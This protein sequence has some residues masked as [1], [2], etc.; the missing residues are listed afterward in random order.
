[1]KRLLILIILIFGFEHLKSQ[2]IEIGQDANEVK[3]FIEWSTRQRTGFDSY[4]NSMGNNVTWD[5][6]YYNGQITEVIQCYEN[7]VIINL[8]PSV[9]FSRHYN[10]EFG[11]LANVYTQYE[12][13]SVE[14]LIEKYNKI[15]EGR[16]INNL[17]FENDYRHYTKIFLAKNGYATTDFRIIDDSQL[18]SSMRKT[19]KN[20]MENEREKLNQ[21]RLADE[22]EKE[23]IHEIIFKT[24]D[25]EK[26]SKDSYESLISGIKEEIINYFE[27]LKNPRYVEVIKDPLFTDL[28]NFDVKKYRFKNTY[29]AYFKYE[30]KSGIDKSN[31]T[32]IDNESDD[33]YR[34]NEITLISGNDTTC[35][36]FNYIAIFIPELHINGYEVLTEVH[37]RNINVDYA[38][39]I[40]FI[41]AKNGEIDFLANKP[42]NDLIDR[43]KKEIHS[44]KNGKY[45]LKYEFK[46]IMGEEKLEIELVKNTLISFGS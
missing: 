15:Y 39:G 20:R 46:S 36:L 14:K 31:L 34:T 22:K 32:E 8:S 45:Y 35:S 28:K 9:N 23:K 7:Q 26:Y 33:I 16:I 37:V 38:K 27:R 12:N 11:K 24:Y 10:M 42:D 3:Q 2:S 6:K 40:T 17:Y 30:I 41:K 18:T 43:I 29:T 44:T 13:V 4:G 19:I 1:M 5:V 25:L 21:I